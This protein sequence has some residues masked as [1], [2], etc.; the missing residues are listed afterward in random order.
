MKAIIQLSTCNPELPALVK[1][2]TALVANH[3]EHSSSEYMKRNSD[4]FVN[5][6]LLSLNILLQCSLLVLESR[7]LHPDHFRCP[8]EVLD[9]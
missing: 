6:S 4:T 8:K 3:M 2:L 9:T 1:E 7:N 5:V